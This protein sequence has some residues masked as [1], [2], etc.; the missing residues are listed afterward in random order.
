MTLFPDA[1]GSIILFPD[2]FGSIILFPEAFGF[3]TVRIFSL[4]RACHFL[5]LSFLLGVL[6]I[7]YSM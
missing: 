6:N 1:F 7:L 3:V 2:A 4:Y 5:G